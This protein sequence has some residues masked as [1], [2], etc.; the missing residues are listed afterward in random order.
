[1][2]NRMRRH[3]V[4][5]ERCDKTIVD[6][7]VAFKDVF[8]HALKRVHRVVVGE[9]INR[10]THHRV[11][12]SNFVQ[13]ENVINVIVREEDAI[14]ALNFGSQ[15]LLAQIRPCIEQNHPFLTGLVV[16]YECGTRTQPFVARI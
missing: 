12:P 13:S 10:R 15:R 3:A 8:V 6:I 2:L 9:D 5:D 11:E 7:L 14:A 1:M 16:E 4:G